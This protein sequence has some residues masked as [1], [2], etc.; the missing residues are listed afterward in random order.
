MPNKYSPIR[1]LYLMHRY[2][3]NPMRQCTEP[4]TNLQIRE[5]YEYQKEIRKSLKASN[6]VL[7][8][9]LRERKRQVDSAKANSRRVPATPAERYFAKRCFAE[10]RE[11]IFI[12]SNPKVEL[13]AKPMPVVKPMPIKV[14]IQIEEQH[15]LSLTIPHHPV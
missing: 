13:E 9:A 7:R 1:N 14:S 10:L 2:V 11:N 6:H 15:V 8:K 12:E 3:R 4:L 5:A